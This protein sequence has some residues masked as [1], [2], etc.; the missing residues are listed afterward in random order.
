MAETRAEALTHELEDALQRAAA[1]SLPPGSG[2]AE[3]D[4]WSV[5]WLAVY[6]A[7]V[8]PELVRDLI[9]QLNARAPEPEGPSAP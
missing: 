5:G 4:T 8:D 2:R 7:H 9:Q 1:A 6:L 3:Q